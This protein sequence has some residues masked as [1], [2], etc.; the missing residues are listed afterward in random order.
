[1]SLYIGPEG[2]VFPCVT[3]PEPLGSLHEESMRSI[4]ERSPALKRIQAQRR[5]DRPTCR[6]C[7]LRDDCS[8]C[9]GQ[10]FLHDG[11]PLEP[12]PVICRATWAQA[13]AK[14]RSRGHMDPPRPPGLKR[15]SFPILNGSV[16]L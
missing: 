11:D 16:A 5:I 6:D 1:L 14:A 15:P 2:G 8:Y 7:H 12:S 9:A 13:K 3:W 4:W 10:A